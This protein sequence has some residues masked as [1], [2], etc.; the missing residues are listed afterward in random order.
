MD[1]FR[2]NLHI[3]LEPGDVNVPLRAHFP[4]ASASTANDGAIPYGSTL[5]NCTAY[6]HLGDDTAYDGTT[7]MIA[8]VEVSSNIAV[9][10]L[11][12]TSDLVSGMYHITWK[13]QFALT[14]TTRLM[15]RQF[16]Y[17]RVLVGNR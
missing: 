13:P 11:T 8:A 3:T 12:W 17:D 7:M 4:P 5:A 14:G 2:G 1:N 16:D 6:A 15:T 10:Y 9:A